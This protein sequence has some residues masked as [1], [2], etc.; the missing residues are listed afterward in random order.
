[1]DLGK[2]LARYGADHEQV[3]YHESHP[4]IIIA[5]HST[6]L[7]PS[8]GGARMLP[9]GEEREALIDALRLSRGMTY[10]AAAAGLDLGGGKAVIIGDPRKDKSPEFYRT[11]GQLLE[12]L[13]GRYITAEDVNTDVRDM[14]EIHKYTNHVRGFE[15]PSPYTALG[16]L[17]AMLG[18]LEYREGDDDLNG[19][20]VNVKGVGKVGFSLVGHLV[21]AGARVTV[22]DINQ[23]AIERVTSQYPQVKVAS[24]QVIHRLPCDIYAPCALGA[25]LNEETIPELDCLMVIGSANNQLAKPADGERLANRGILYAP[26]YIANAGGLMSVAEKN[27]DKLLVR[28]KGIKDT[29]R[30]VLTQAEAL[31]ML[32]YIFANQMAEDSINQARERQGL[33]P[34]F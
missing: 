23:Q 8:L 2:E 26:D 31:G 24:H 25:D 22:A 9:Y 15:D 34:R 6:D 3:V 32:P 18:G 4:R 29:T 33:S 28:V 27:H 14:E 10:K 17:A 12:S 13:N 16:V 19:R 20:R 30:Y 21:G 1:M 11:F 5:I 7:G